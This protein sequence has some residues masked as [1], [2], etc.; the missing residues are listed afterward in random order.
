MENYCP[1][2]FTGLFVKKGDEL[3]TQV[4]HCCV[5]E[6][7]LPRWE[8]SLNDPHLEKSRNYFLKTGE[9]P[10]GCSHCKNVEKIG[11][12]S[13]RTSRLVQMTE[14]PIN[15]VLEKLDYNCDNICNLKCILCN[16]DYSSSWIED[17]IK[18]E[19]L[20]IVRFGPKRYSNTKHNN[21]IN[22]L[23][24]SNLKQIYFNGGEPLMSKDHIN[25]LN[26]IIKSKNPLDV[27]VRYSSNGNFPFTQEI[28]DL[29]SRFKSI[30]FQISL[31]AIGDCYEY[32][33][34]PAN[35]STVEEN[36]LSYQHSNLTNLKLS[37]SAT[38]GLYNIL[39]FND[40]Y[41]WGLTN[42][43]EVNATGFTHGHLSMKN[44]PISYKQILLDYEKTIPERH[45]GVPNKDQIRSV[46]D[47]ID[48]NQDF[49][50]IK[51]LNNLDLIRGTS[52]KKSLNK[53]YEID[54]I[55]FDSIK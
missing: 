40:L 32:T 9:L 13:L 43:Y 52:W 54:P 53:L 21:S 38:L 51:F 50:W 15:V 47:S 29:W 35:W 3:T 19:K 5:S 42:N 55:F 7:S 24:L 33:R 2:L 25:V 4:S 36:L 41:K 39:Y 20:G 28:L 6:L 12:M 45:I 48:A 10:D 31:D 16:S 30:D 8:I 22:N 46:I 44:F 26:C 27:N 17:D 23:D 34:F 37:I 18:L 49:E 1:D 14:Y 11:L